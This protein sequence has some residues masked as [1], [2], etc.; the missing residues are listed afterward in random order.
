MV[1]LR[2]A[3][4]LCYFAYLLPHQVLTLDDEV[5]DKFNGADIARRFVTHI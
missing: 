5:D 3:K 1:T 2:E 4:Y